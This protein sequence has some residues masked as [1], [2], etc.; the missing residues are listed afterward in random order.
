MQFNRKF[1][2]IGNV[3]KPTFSSI[4]RLLCRS[5]GT[6]FHQP[7][8]HNE[9]SM[10]SLVSAACEHLTE[11]TPSWRAVESVACVGC[12]RCHLY[13]I[14]PGRH[15]I[16][17]TISSST[18]RLRDF[19]QNSVTSPTPV[20]PDCST[21]SLKP[22]SASSPSSSTFSEGDVLSLAMLTG[23]ATRSIT[24]VPSAWSAATISTQ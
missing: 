12:T 14:G 17:T 2:R 7:A 24:D 16:S 6:G 22:F 19:I 11:R 9:N 8:V 23:W 1:H 20:L 3:Y 5:T 10:K 18:T 4:H 15:D 13:L 21:D